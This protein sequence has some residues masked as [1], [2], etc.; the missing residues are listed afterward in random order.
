VT[1]P[2]RLGGA[3][4]GWFSRNPYVLPA[5]ITVVGAA[6][7]FYNLN[8]D[9]GHQLHPDER[10][11]YEVLSG[12]N[13]NP[14]LSWPSS[15]SQFTA[16]QDPAGGSPLNPHFF[17]YGSLPFYL[18][19][20]LAG[21]VSFVGQHVPLFSAWA[22]VDTYS[23]LPG[24][25]RGF[26]GCLDL[27]SVWL[28]FVLGRRVFGHWAGVLAMAFTAFTVLDIQ[29]SHFFTV[30]TVLLP[31]CLLTLLAAVRIATED[32]R[33]PYVWGGIVFGA[34]MATKTTALLLFLPL[35][36]AAVLR[37]SRL[38]EWPASGD[39]WDRLRRHYASRASGLNRNLQWL[40][41]TYVIAAF[42]FALCEPYALLDRTQLVHD[43]SEQT[44]FLVTNDP[45]FV[46]PFTIQY[47]G[48][49]PYLYQ[50]KNI[51]FWSMGIP[52]ALAAFAGVG[53]GVWR[54]ARGR[55]RADQIV[56]LLWV[57][58]YFLFVGR[59]FAKF[60]RYM[61]PILPV[62]GLFGAALLVAWAR[63]V[64]PR[65]SL[66]GRVAL[67]GVVG[68]SFL[69]SLAY[70]NVYA[71]PNTRVAAS[72]W[73]YA[74]IPAGSTIGI[75]SAWDDALPLDE[76]GHSGGLIYHFTHM[77]LYDGEDATTD[78]DRKIG[79]ITTVLQQSNYIVMTS[80]RL[81][82]SIPKLPLRYPI[83]NRYYQLLFAGKLNFRLERVF[84]AHPQLGPVTVEDYG[85]DES[86][87]VYDHP[88]V[89]IWKRTGPISAA[90]VRA[91]LTSGLPTPPAS[92]DPATLP[93]I[94]RQAT[95][96]ADT[97]LMLSPSQWHADQQGGTYDQMF[98]PGGFAMNHP[99]LVWWLMLEVLGLIVFP[100]TF[101]LFSRLIDRGFVLAKTFGLLA[102]G[103]LVW[104]AVSAGIGVYDRT[105]IVTALAVLCAVSAGTAYRLRVSLRAFFLTRWKYALAG[106][107]VFLAGFVAFVLLRMWYPD[108]GHQFS[109]VSPLN[110][111]AGRMGEKQMEL[112]YL[113]AIVRSRVF[114][115]YDPFF[116]HGYINYY[117]YGFYLVGTLCKLVQILPATGFNL[118]IAT[119]FGMLAGNVFSVGLNL[120][121][122]I[123]P[124]VLAA[125]FVGAIGNLNGAW[126][127]MRSLMTVAS[128]H[129][130]VP[131]AGGV[132][133]IL[134]GL[135]A[136]LVDR[137]PLPPFDFW[138]PTRIVP[139]GDISEFPYFT[140]LFADL[141]PHLIAFPM[142]VAALALAVQLL[143]GG[144]QSMR[145]RA[146]AALFG[147][148]LLGAIAVTNPWDY[149]TYLLI[150]GVGALISAYAG[151]RRLSLG[152]LAR[153][154]GWVVALAGLSAVL[155]LPFKQSYQTVFATGIGLVRDITP[156]FLEQQG[157]C[158]D[159]SQYCPG[160]AHDVLVT[161][162]SIYL[163]HFGLFLFVLLSYPIVLLTLDLGGK[164]SVARLLMWV[165][166]A[167]YYRDRLPRVWRAARVARAMA[168]S[169]TWPSDVSTVL[170]MVLVLFLLLVLRY[171]LLAFLIASLG[172]LSLL[173][174]SLGR[175]LPAG[176]L[177][178]LALI[179]VGL[180][181][182][183]VTQVVFVKDWLAGGPEFRMN[184]IF[185]FYNQVWVLYAV[186]AACLLYHL[187]H[188]VVGRMPEDVFVGWAR[189]HTV[190]GGDTD[191]PGAPAGAPVVM[192]VQ[193]RLA[194]GGRLAA[195]WPLTAGFSAQPSGEAGA[196]EIVLPARPASR[197]RWG[198]IPPRLPSVLT[199]LRRPVAMARQN[200]LWSIC[201]ALL[202]GASL[203]YTYAG[204]V[205]RETYRETWLPENS[206][207]FTLD[208]M[209][210][211]KVAYPGEYDAVNWLNAHVRG[212]PVIAE[213]G[214]ADYD[215]RSRVSMFTGLPTIINGIHEAEQRYGDEIDPSALCDGTRNPDACRARTHSRPTDVNDLYDSPSITDAWR[216]IRRYDVRYIYVGFIERMCNKDS[217]SYQCFSRAGLA[218]FDRMVG[219][220]LAKVYDRGG[221]TIYQ[222]VKIGR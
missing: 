167:F 106:E 181:I 81:I 44:T 126:Q 204:T 207:P 186:A 119:F 60:N 105:M 94:L 12:A 142:T 137:Q 125:V 216:I 18:L 211:M 73:I 112:A 91:L 68:G 9:N 210:F 21:A 156:Q 158:P 132:I 74:N 157:V 151:R 218:K 187:M 38:E 111:G 163:E 172:L 140:Y 147:A 159:Q 69:Y 8:W 193:R 49:V 190:P 124:G 217:Q 16:V 116:A 39:F 146:L 150:V 92:V 205:A 209:A 61:L 155:Y 52:L 198:R 169:G 34:A 95:A 174:V 131:V 93:A 100:F 97:R 58:P 134:S 200:S 70:M 165:R 189:Q 222:V 152:L 31:F 4:G 10:W 1:R 80:D 212:A 11:I 85:A 129:S 109:P 53:Y 196:G 28:V 99:L 161:P 220:G 149:P 178:V 32:S 154:A 185:K 202:F 213:A 59:F 65:W 135:R 117:Y 71:Q 96:K 133:D 127:L 77:E 164:R 148:G 177:F 36:A 88:I 136:T 179:G 173:V 214:P 22:N 37:A 87:H 199:G 162:L 139:G 26:S 180:L 35:G 13:G 29:L 110:L 43:I 201:L 6:F 168:G 171:Y 219:H 191:G 79:A 114:P 30:D 104:L 90:R 102:L 115:P 176:Q 50:I 121:R 215:W 24:L 130:S 57:I 7:R 108:L 138:E 51:L 195:L 46:V 27:V 107:L 184:T 113:N 221:V 82:G 19:A 84:Q 14:P 5:I 101:L 188:R 182:S 45:P 66:V 2:G 141:H 123:T 170:G 128:V 183:V 153:P 83:A 160:V 86:F 166:F 194:S 20:L 76:Q 42:V 25:G 120:T 3:I 47:A 23:G 203:I 54:I 64:Q 67:V 63:S 98:P 48:T 103:Y 206:V 55:L 41:G 75:E 33:A 15:W 40:L 197:G 208:G 192:S 118:A 175:R 56:L 144:Y 72:R 143:R 145:K 78:E 122:R 89:R 62:M 17:A